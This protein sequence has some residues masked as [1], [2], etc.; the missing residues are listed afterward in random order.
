[1]RIILKGIYLYFSSIVLFILVSILIWL[2]IVD[3]I[4][5]FSQNL[6][7]REQIRG[8]IQLEDSEN[9][10]WELYH[11]GKNDVLIIKSLLEMDLRNRIPD[12]RTAERFSK[13]L[14]INDNYFQ[15]RFLDTTGR[16]VIKVQRYGRDVRIA[17]TRELQLKGHH[18]YFKKS[19]ALEDGEVFVSE[20]NLNVENGAIEVPYRPTIRLFA[21]VFQGGIKIGVV[22]L[23]VNFE[24]W[25]NVFEGKNIGLLNERDE[26]YFGNTQN[27]YKKSELNLEA[28][29]HH[30]HPEY[31]SKRI[32]LEGD[33]HWTLYTRSDTVA[34]DAQIKMFRRNNYLLG[35][36]PIFGTLLLL[37]ITNILY[38]RKNRIIKLNHDIAK[39]I[40]E[41]DILIKEIHH[42]VKNNLQVVS[43]LLRLQGSYIKDN[44]IREIFRH[45]QYR[46]NSMG[47]IHEMLYSNKDMSR[48]DYGLYV[49]ELVDSLLRAM[50]D[51]NHKIELRCNVND[52]HLNVDTSIPLGLMINEI[53]T[54]SLKYGFAERDEGNLTIG[55]EKITALQYRM[56]IGDDG[57]GYTPDFNLKNNKSLGLKLIHRL[58][59]QLKGQVKKDNSK[60]G[61][62]Y[63]ITFREIVQD[64]PFIE[65]N[66]G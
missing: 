52:I 8:N 54:N 51:K 53:I 22:G 65:K 50:K 7:A 17:E 37:V 4:E 6:I 1:M 23:N 55:I 59:S 47:L 66:H 61:T 46:I 62:H 25:L 48:I 15:A 16:E 42:R 31:F 58:A 56:Y 12:S 2:L 43:S 60:P 40:D 28:E 20:L 26:V 49:R 57:K 24:D 29:D 19:V 3:R 33:H 14:E 63:I 39:R 36:I 41:R 18:N 35:A 5:T 27:L 10:L 34:I 9:Q 21:P 13:V 64:Q 45:S 44:K 11:T 38:R 30:G 32:Y